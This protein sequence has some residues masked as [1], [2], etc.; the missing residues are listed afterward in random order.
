MKTHYTRD[1]GME[2]RADRGLDLIIPHHTKAASPA[3]AFAI[4]EGDAP[5]GAQQATRRHPRCVGITSCTQHWV[6]HKLQGW[7]GIV[8]STC[9]SNLL[10]RWLPVAV[11]LIPQCCST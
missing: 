8:Q 9:L 6:R 4:L 5:S 3:C 10:T 1:T 11:L 2:T 7:L